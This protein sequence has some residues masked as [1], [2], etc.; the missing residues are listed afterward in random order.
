MIGSAEI[1]LSHPKM[2]VIYKNKNI[3]ENKFVVYIPHF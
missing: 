1:I 2:D 3:S